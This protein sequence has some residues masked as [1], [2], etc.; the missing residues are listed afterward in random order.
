MLYRKSYYRT[1]QHENEGVTSYEYIRCGRG[2][3]CVPVL[4]TIDEA[5]TTGKLDRTK[6]RVR[7][8][9]AIDRIYN[10]NIRIIASSV[11]DAKNQSKYQ[12]K[13][14][15]RKQQIAPVENNRIN[16]IQI[17]QCSQSDINSIDGML[18]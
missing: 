11:K 8:N 5:Q 16:T 13:Y 14:N 15:R 17:A 1:Y 10:E 4:V 2:V 18:L 6:K 7:I 12:S 9:D 3:W